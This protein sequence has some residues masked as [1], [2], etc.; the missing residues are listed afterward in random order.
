MTLP[1]DISKSVL[2]SFSCGPDSVFLYYYLLQQGLRKNQIYL[3]YFDHGLRPSE[4]STEKQFFEKFLSRENVKGHWEALPVVSHADSSGISLEMSGRQLRYTRLRLIAADLGIDIVLTAHHKND[5]IESFFLRLFRGTKQLT[6]PIRE[7]FLLSDNIYCYRP[8]LHLFKKDILDF[9]R[10]NH[11]LYCIDTSNSDHKYQRNQIRYFLPEFEKINNNALDHVSGFINY[12]SSMHGYFYVKLESFI[13]EFI[14]NLTISRL[15]LSKLDAVELRF[16]LSVTLPEILPDDACFNVNQFE[17][18]IDFISSNE[19][20]DLS[21]PKGYIIQFSQAYMTVLPEIQSISFAYT[22]DFQ[23]FFISEINSKI[24]FDFVGRE[25][26]EFKNRFVAY[27]SLPEGVDHI[28]IRG[29]QPGD[30]IKSLGMSGYKKVSDVFIDKKV[31]RL[32]RP[33]IPLFFIENQLVW[34]GGYCVSEDFKITPETKTILRIEI[35]S[36]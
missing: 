30:K 2:L 11:Y 8:I 17:S 16:F 33:K 24:M 27:L 4:V 28:Q 19:C 29:F 15:K 20:G 10:K 25:A 13:S 23:T 14:F 31:E 12:L 32:K 35:K 21:L 18:I 9:L 6:S 5:V 7:T 36:L 34:I 22:S 3:I 26:V 1:F